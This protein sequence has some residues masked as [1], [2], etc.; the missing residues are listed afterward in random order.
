MKN[1]GAISSVA[2][3]FE[4]IFR[5]TENVGGEDPTWGFSDAQGVA[6]IGSALRRFVLTLLPKDLGKDAERAAHF[7]IIDV[8]APA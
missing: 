6:V 2:S 1:D 4:T 3:F 8:S 7:A 5:Y